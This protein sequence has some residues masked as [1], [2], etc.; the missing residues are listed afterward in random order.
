[1]ALQISNLKRRLRHVREEMEDKQVWIKKAE[2]EI[3]TAD[4]FVRR[5]TFKLEWDQGI[6]E[7]MQNEYDKRNRWVIDEKKKFP[8]DFA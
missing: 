4:V 1:M 7:E 3:K 8:L 2:K 6:T 5:N